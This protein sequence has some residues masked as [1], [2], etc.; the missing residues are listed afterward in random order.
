[1]AIEGA[2]VAISGGDVDV[3]LLAIRDHVIRVDVV[4]DVI[5]DNLA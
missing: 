4:G 2:E 5:V 3:G 1:V